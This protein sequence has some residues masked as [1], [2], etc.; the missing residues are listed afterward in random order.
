MPAN[1]THMAAH[2]AQVIGSVD[3]TKPRD[4]RPAHQL[5]DDS[6]IRRAA[7]YSRDEV[8]RT[9]RAFYP[10]VFR[11]G[12]ALCGNPA[13]GDRVVRTVMNRS[14]HAL[15]MWKSANQAANWFLHQTVFVSRSWSRSTPAAGGPDDV[16]MAV[17]AG[18]IAPVEPGYV[19][20]VKA[21][22][23]LPFQQAEAFI[24]SRGEQVDPRRL[25]VGMDCSTE[26]AANHLAAANRT[27]SSIA[28]EQ[29][30]RYAGLLAQAYMRLSPSE[31][32][33]IGDIHARVGG[34]L[35][36][37]R[38]WRVLNLIISLA[39]IA[40]MVWVVWKIYPMLVI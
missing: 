23:S 34:H 32:L 12:H 15:R 6:V 9:L 16:L 37:R 5:P 20:F 13:A 1:N 33:T 30:Q 21:L 38:A 27:L 24:L 40:G 18:P 7:K 14:L 4:V 25:A 35:L 2:E 19:A 28:G 10:Q 29:F 26:A 8:E 17:G 36:R 11:F 31:E 22:R 3:S 39:L